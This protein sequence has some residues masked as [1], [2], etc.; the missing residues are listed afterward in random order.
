L[1]D[2]ELRLVQTMEGQIAGLTMALIR[3]ARAS[4]DPANIAAELEVASEMFTDDSARSTGAAL[5]LHLLAN[6]IEQDA[7]PSGG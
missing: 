5:M 7:P 2:D 3:I 6:A 4:A 1:T